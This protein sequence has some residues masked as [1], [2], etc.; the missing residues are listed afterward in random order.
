MTNYKE[1]ALAALPGAEKK[2]GWWWH[3][4]RQ[5]QLFGPDGLS[6]SWLAVAVRYRKNAKDPSGTGDTAQSALN[7]L[8]AKL[9][10]DDLRRAFP[11]PPRLTYSEKCRLHAIKRAAECRAILQAFRSTIGQHIP[12]NPVPPELVAWQPGEWVAGR[13]DRWVHGGGSYCAGIENNRHYVGMH[14]GGEHYGT[15]Y[16]EAITNLKAAARAAIGPEPDRARVTYRVDT[17]SSPDRH[18]ATLVVNGRHV[19]ARFLR[20]TPEQA[21]ADLKMF[22]VWR[23]C[24]ALGFEPQEEP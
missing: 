12:T 24:V 11:E 7:N 6:N 15:S 8:R 1:Q 20:N 19:A 17:S 14:G 2:G 23:A 5:I 16:T 13:V 9:T 21:I 22:A 10:G 3:N 18:V 4:T